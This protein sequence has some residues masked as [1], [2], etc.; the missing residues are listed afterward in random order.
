MIPE[1][2]MNVSLETENENWLSIL[3]DVENEIIGLKMDKNVVKIMA[4]LWLWN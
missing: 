3:S 2:E 4:T 1:Q